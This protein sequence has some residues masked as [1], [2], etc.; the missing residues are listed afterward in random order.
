M[1][2]S[3][4]R[5]CIGNA[6]TPPP[7]LHTLHAYYTHNLCRPRFES[8]KRVL[9]FLEVHDPEFAHECRERLEYIDKYVHHK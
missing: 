7:P 5:V 9:Q 3:A 8:K 4:L 6:L 2:R 1:I